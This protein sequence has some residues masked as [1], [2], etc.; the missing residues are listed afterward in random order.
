MS[1]QDVE[2]QQSKRLE[3]IRA[4]VEKTDLI[5][6]LEAIEGLNALYTENP[7][8]LAQLPRLFSSYSHYRRVRG[9]GICFYRGALFQL[10]TALRSGGVC[11]PGT[12]PSPTSPLQQGYEALLKRVDGVCSALSKHG[13]D[14]LIKDFMD[15]LTTYLTDLSDPANPD[16]VAGPLSGGGEGF[17]IYGLRLCTCAEI[18]EDPDSNGYSLFIEGGFG[19]PT[20][21]FCDEQVLRAFEE[22][23]EIQILALARF[24]G[25][26][27]Q[28]VSVDAHHFHINS[29]PE[30]SERVRGGGEGDAM[31]ALLLPLLLRPG[32]YD[33]LTLRG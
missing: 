23:D 33:C 7:G 31:R 6:P 32:H 28:I 13:F 24:L 26:T 16:P 19:L 20:K 30:A 14:D 4:E 29:I 1:D 15:S 18:L 17:I 9:D 22:A 10:G 27:V 5:G 12:S 25:V 3:E 8:F 2:Q 11:P 21:T